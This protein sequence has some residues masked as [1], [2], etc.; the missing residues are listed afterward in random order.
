MLD[1]TS[2]YRDAKDNGAKIRVLLV[3]TTVR[4][5]YVFAE[6]TPTDDEVGFLSSV[7]FWDGSATT[8]DGGTF[9]GFPVSSTRGLVLGLG[10]I[11]ETLTPQRNDLLTSLTLLRLFTDESSLYIHPARGKFSM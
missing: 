1:I 7:D 6:T 9:G 3:I 11:S 8:G 2:D 5:R 4:T 10:G